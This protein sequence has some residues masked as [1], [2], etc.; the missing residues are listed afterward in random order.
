MAINLFTN[1]LEQIEFTG[2]FGD[3][4]GPH[5]E[6]AGFPPEEIASNS[7]DCN[8]SVFI[9]KRNEELKKHSSEMA[10]YTKHM[11]LGSSNLEQTLPDTTLVTDAPEAPPAGIQLRINKRI[12][13]LKSSPSYDKDVAGLVL[14]LNP[15]PRVKTERL[16]PIL[17]LASEHGR[18]N[19]PEVTVAYKLC[20][21]DCIHLECMDN[22]GQWKLVAID[23]SRA[24]R[25]TRPLLVAN[26]PEVRTYRARFWDKGVAHGEWSPL[27]TIQVL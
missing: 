18:N 25:D 10:A 6:K 17:N 22:N 11:L 26:V 7:V 16:N 14:R 13:H 2:N 21:H 4:F 1:V 8:Y 19:Q 15:Q 23:N 20:G 3:N 5:A 12:K 27:V 24:Y 9:L